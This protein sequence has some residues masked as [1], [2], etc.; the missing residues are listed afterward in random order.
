MQLV[1]NDIMIWHAEEPDILMSQGLPPEECLYWTSLYDKDMNLLDE[2][3]NRRVSDLTKDHII[4]I[5]K[6]MKEH[7]GKI[8]PEM[9]QAF[10]NVLLRPE[11]TLDDYSE[12]K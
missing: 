7:N 3:L 8:S 12:M 6:Y 4:A 2:P 1:P 5:D 11:I 10:V 9:E